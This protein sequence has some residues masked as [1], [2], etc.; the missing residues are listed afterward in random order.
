MRTGK[1]QAASKIC[2]DKI[3]ENPVLLEVIM[4]ETQNMNQS[5]PGNTSVLHYIPEP[6][7]HAKLKPDQNC[8]ARHSG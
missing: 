7:V 2:L 8:T 3:T 5:C 6:I 4:I 1:P